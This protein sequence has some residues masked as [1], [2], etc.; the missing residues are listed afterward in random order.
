MSFVYNTLYSDP[1]I[2]IKAIK[3]RCNYFSIEINFT[4]ASK[5]VVKVSKIEEIL[6]NFTAA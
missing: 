6:I 2:H 4:A 1:I 5:G 3:A